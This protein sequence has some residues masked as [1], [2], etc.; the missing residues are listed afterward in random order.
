MTSWL[1]S[2]LR[3]KGPQAFG[4]PA[5]GSGFLVRDP[6]ESSGRIL[7]ETFERHWHQLRGIATH[8]TA[9][10]SADDVVAVINLLDQMIALLQMELSTEA[11]DVLSIDEGDSINEDPLA[12]LS[13]SS[14]P[15]LDILLSENIPAHILAAARMPLLPEQQDRLRAQQLKLYEAL[16]GGS[17]SRAKH[18]L[19]HQP[20]LKPLIDLLSEFVSDSDAD[21]HS[22]KIHQ[23]KNAAEFT[24]LETEL[25]LV[26]VLNLLCSRLMEK[27]N[28]H[29]LQVF[30]NVGHQ[31]DGTSDDVPN[32]ENS[33]SPKFL[34]FSILVEFL[35]RDGLV[36]QHARDAL[37]LSMSLSNKHQDLGRH[38]TK[39]TNFCPVL[40]TGLSGLYSLLPRHLVQS[41]TTFSETGFH[42]ISNADLAEMPE[43]SA[44]LSS[45]QFCD[46]V[47]Q[48][49]HPSVRQHLLG[50][51]YMGFLV[52][53]L[54]PALTQTIESEL[55]CSTAYVEL[56]L[57][58]ISE[59]ALL[60]VFLRYIFTDTCEGKSIIDTLINRIALQSQLC[61]V[62]LAL[63][64]T[65][66]GLNCE[67]VMLWLVF[68]HLIPMH[69]LLPIQRVTIRQPDLLGRAA[70]KF[71]SLT[72]ICCSESRSY[73]A[74]EAKEKGVSMNLPTFL[75]GLSRPSV[76]DGISLDSSISGEFSYNSYLA[77]A[78]QLVRLRY[79]ATQCWLYDYDG[80]NPPP[81]D[82]KSQFGHRVVS[83]QPSV[84]C[85][86]EHPE[87]PR[88]TST[89][90]G[91]SGPLSL[92]DEELD[93]D[94]WN[95][96]K[97]DS[98]VVAEVRQL[99]TSLIKS[100]G[101]NISMSSGGISLN[102]SQDELSPRLAQEANDLSPPNGSLGSFLDLV[103]EKVELMTS[104][105][106]TT[107]L[108]VTSLISQLASYP[109]P[110]LRSVLI[111]PDVVLQ[112]SV[113]GL[114]GAIASVR[115]KLD[116]IMPTLSGA[117]EAVQMARRFLV[118]RLT[119]SQ[120][121][122]RD[123]NISIMSS[124]STFGQEARATRNSFS[125][126]FSSMFRRKSGL[127]NTDSL[128][129]YHSSGEG[130]PSAP[131]ARR[132]VQFSRRLSREAKQLA[133]AAVI[134]E[135]W[136][137]ELAAIA[138]EQS[139]LQKEQAAYHLGLAASLEK[140]MPGGHLME[141][142]HNSNI[143]SSAED[144]SLKETRS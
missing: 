74:Q 134:L 61:V 22:A 80:L 30:F 10:P 7:A 14:S 5:M 18:L 82:Q 13:D 91:S 79:E 49:A 90:T 67:D 31:I 73:V 37:L 141:G 95:L 63:F 103:L 41:P 142:K 75:V 52:P 97:L 16:L 101:D 138:Q 86:N 123:S 56:F 58:R 51:I 43:L 65:L 117:E 84:S 89:P 83:R 76:E 106:L 12:S 70:E 64:E 135:E 88:M 47:V 96:M 129:P 124:I 81:L 102:S 128:P 29:L 39:H 132:S 77:D 8:N 34:I 133:L 114:Y 6:G 9:V 48:V 87:G 93:R 66:I 113:R 109:Q 121:K 71:L 108:L 125:A 122:R 136:L 104:N 46:A 20:F 72:P 111:H 94:F 11:E 32:G 23:F 36:G 126:A 59:P 139:L 35:H 27:D 26:M 40:A 24:S 21:F 144:G 45:L 99:Q 100:Q 54:G 120:P 85:D 92:T 4:Y 69:H 1:R 78:R 38:I 60:A 140:V 119:V 112:P 127:T 130:S 53:V 19:S 137:Q 105:D 15:C 44:F 131:Q 98:S 3:K 143:L 62:T 28:R 50:L 115:Q 2:S 17:S 25:H 55:I 42:R 110:L 57:R 68:R 107:N 33:V 116:N 118:D